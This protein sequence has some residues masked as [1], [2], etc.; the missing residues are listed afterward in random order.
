MINA[1]IDLEPIAGTFHCSWVY[2]C[3]IVEQNL[4]IIV[5]EYLSLHFNLKNVI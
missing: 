2:S 4:K 5:L 3:G 1:E